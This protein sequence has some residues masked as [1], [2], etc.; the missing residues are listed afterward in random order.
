[1]RISMKNYMKPVPRTIYYIHDTNTYTTKEPNNAVNYDVYELQI[2]KHQK[3]F[4][5]NPCDRKNFKNTLK[6]VSVYRNIYENT[7]DIYLYWND[8][9]S[10]LYRQYCSNGITSIDLALNQSL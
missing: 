2:T 10:S 5:H 1:M 9:K 6:E 3:R 7:A 4:D 8:Y